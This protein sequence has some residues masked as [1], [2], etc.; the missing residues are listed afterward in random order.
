[1]A[2]VPRTPAIHPRES[3]PSSTSTET[4]PKSPTPIGRMATHA[5]H[6]AFF[7]KREREAT[8]VTKLGKRRSRDAEASTEAI[9]DRG[10]VA[11]GGNRATP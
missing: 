11:R 5:V 1:M 2:S 4:R 3:S 9:Y 7:P 8:D 6:Q 10:E